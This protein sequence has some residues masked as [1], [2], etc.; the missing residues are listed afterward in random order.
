MSITVLLADD[1]AV[2]RDGLQA[3]LQAQ[4]DIEVVG[5]AANA[6]DAIQETVRLSPDVAIV[7]I[8]MPGLNGIHATRQISEVCP[9]TQVIILS[10]YSTPEYVYRALRAGARGYMVK[11]S[12]GSEVVEAIRAVHS[13]FRYLSRKIES[14]V[15]DEYLR[16]GEALGRTG[17]L[18]RLTSREREVLELVVEGKTSTEIGEILF[19]S[20]RT[21]EGY[22]RSLKKNLG[23]GDLPGLVKFA[24]QHGL[25]RLR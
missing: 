6:R 13:G 1:H 16:Q 11:Q 22:R 17:P 3:L 4:G 9:A 7:D 12:A 21:V 14:T 25:I 8:A 15:V 10:M 20:P 5:H 24:I 19:L 18:A 2:V 23:I